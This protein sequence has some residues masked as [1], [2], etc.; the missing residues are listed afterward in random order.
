MRTFTLFIMAILINNLPLSAAETNAPVIKVDEKHQ[1]KNYP[2]DKTVETYQVPLSSSIILDAA[3]YTF[4]IPS[5]LQNQPINS[6]WVTQSTEE[7]FEVKW[8]PGTTR[9]ELSKETLRPRPGSGAFQGF[10]AGGKVYVTI[11]VVDKERRSTPVWSTVVQV[12]K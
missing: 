9:Y 11:C 10:R 4:K 6:I 12:E 8:Q 1:W 2:T 5:S 7:Q 3:D